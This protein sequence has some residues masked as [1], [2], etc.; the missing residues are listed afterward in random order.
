MKVRIAVVVL[1]GILCATAP[2]WSDTIS[3]HS[4]DFGVVKDAGQVDTHHAPSVTSLASFFSSDSSKFNF[5]E[6]QP[7]HR[8]W[9]GW[10]QGR[11]VSDPHSPTAT[12]TPVS[13]PEPGT[14]P[15]LAL[16]MG[17]L[18]SALM[19]SSSRSRRV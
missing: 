13:A 1:A 2:A 7:N 18:G 14:L 6:L 17:L 19:F 8:I 4:R 16:G 9:D 11:E 10:G 5:V 12:T 15:M 3:G